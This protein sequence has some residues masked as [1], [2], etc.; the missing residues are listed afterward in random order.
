MGAELLRLIHDNGFELFR[1]FKVP[2][3]TFSP[4]DLS[5]SVFVC[6]HAITYD[7]VGRFGQKISWLSKLVESNCWVC[8]LDHSALRAGPRPQIGHFLPI[9]YLPRAKRQ[10]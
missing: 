8:I 4:M 1:V 6:S 3:C 7:L 2:K 5:L 9:I 10:W